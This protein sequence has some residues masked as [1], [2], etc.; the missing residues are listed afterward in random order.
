MA[1]PVP[2]DIPL[3]PNVSR[4]DRL[5]DAAGV[6]W[7]P[8]FTTGRWGLLERFLEPVRGA[9]ETAIHAFYAKCCRLANKTEPGPERHDAVLRALNY[10]V[11]QR[12]VLLR[13]GT[14][15]LHIRELLQRMRYTSGTPWVYSTFFLGELGLDWPDVPPQQRF[16]LR[17]KRRP[18][19]KVMLQPSPQRARSNHVRD[20]ER[21]RS[22]DRGP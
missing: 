10:L 11:L 18:H 3:G 1:R 8:I 15:R 7:M 14:R 6:V 12:H 16:Q 22:E 13:S 4:V 20:E 5:V 19:V 21:G 17:V 2:P 9:D